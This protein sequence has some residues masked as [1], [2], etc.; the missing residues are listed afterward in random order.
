MMTA[1][2]TVA[3]ENDNNSGSIG[4]GGSWCVLEAANRHC[5]EATRAEADISVRGILS[6]IR[7]GGFNGVNAALCGVHG[8]KFRKRG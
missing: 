1:M 3:T 6:R 2:V 8:G 5:H 7:S 4:G